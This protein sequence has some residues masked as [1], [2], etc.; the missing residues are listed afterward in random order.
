MRRTIFLILSVIFLISL[1]GCD[2][3]QKQSMNNQSILQIND[4]KIEDTPEID[5]KQLFG[6]AKIR[7]L[8]AQLSDERPWYD[9]GISDK[10]EIFGFAPK[11]NG[12]QGELI[13]YDLNTSETKSL[14]TSQNDANPIFF[15]YND[16]YL[17][18]SELS[19]FDQKTS[20]IVL[21][22]RK[23]KKAMVISEKSKLPAGFTYEMIALGNDH[24]LWSTSETDNDIIKNQIMRYDIRTQKTT[25]FQENATMP[26]I[27]AD[28]IAWLGPD[29]NMRN[30]CIYL[31]NLKDNSI[32]KINTKG[33]H[34]LYINTD[35]ISIVFKGISESDL[36]L[37]TLSIYENEKVQIIKE[38][39]LDNFDFPEISHNFVGWRGTD[40]LRGYSREKAK[41]GILTEK[42]AD[43]TE[44][45]VNNKYIMWHS[46]VIKDENEAKLKAM[47]QHI[48]LSDLNIIS[49]DD[50]T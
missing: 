15:K 17:A 36:N 20:R 30:S 16:N 21:Y 26:I 14:Y 33:Q 39:Y 42:F 11:N 23:L 48:Y 44:V 28:F 50:I 19:N 29:E 18:W 40:K 25:V 1:T 5:Y 38:S 22:D 47:E 24:I 6:D 37:K 8:R 45:K 7:T 41:I 46:P 31:D 43:Y 3:L 4:S 34:P 2:H 32:K 49:T 9:L 12:K 35:G 27:G 13:M 10:G